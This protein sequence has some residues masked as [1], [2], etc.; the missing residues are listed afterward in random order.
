MEKTFFSNFIYKNDL[1]DPVIVEIG[2]INIK[3]ARRASKMFENH[4]YIYYEASKYNYA[5]LKENISSIPNTSAFHY[6]VTENNKPLNFHEF[7]IRRKNVEKNAISASLFDRSKNE[8]KFHIHSKYKVN[9]VT[10]SDILQQ[11]NLEKIDY[12][13]SNCEGGEEGFLTYIVKNPLISK[14]IPQICVA[15]HP[16]IC[17]QKKCDYLLNK[18]NKLYNIK[19]NDSGKPFAS[20]YY[21]LTLK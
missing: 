21:L 4:K 11:N 13:I 9:C 17:G 15:L 18:L 16:R 5:R 12:L 19:Q 8:K 7:G 20:E 14:K 3:G 1:N 6:A 2:S 10:L